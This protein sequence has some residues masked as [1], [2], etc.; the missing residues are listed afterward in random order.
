[1]DNL[2]LTQVLLAPLTPFMGAVIAL[3]GLYSLTVNAA[4]AKRL[5]HKRA[6]R[7]AR[8]GG[9]LYILAGTVILFLRLFY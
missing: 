3:A 9:C 6:A 1:M 4:D 7:V 5:S 8:L 2:P